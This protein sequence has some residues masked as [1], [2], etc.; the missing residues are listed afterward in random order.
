MAVEFPKTPTDL[1]VTAP[2]Y[3][4]KSVE[5]VEDRA[6]LTGRTEF[7]DNVVLPGMLHCAILRSPFAH[8]RIASIDASA[9]EGHPGVMA[10]LTREDA[11]RWSFPGS[12]VPEGWGTHCLATEKVRYVGEPVA[13]VAATS[14]YL[15]EDALEL[16]EVDYQP[17]EPVVEAL[18][19]AE[20]GGPLVNEEQGTNVMVHRVFTWGEVDRAFQEADHVFTESFRWHRVGAN[21]MENFGVISQWDPLEQSVTCRGTFQSPSLLALGRAAVLGL[22]IHK[23]RLISHPRG[24]SF[25]GKMGY[26]GTDITALLSRKAGG[27]PVKWIEDRMEYLTAGSSQA[28]DRHYQAS[29]AVRNDGTVTGFKVNLVEDLG[30]TG[31]GFGS[32]GAVKPLSSFTGCY[33]IPVA[34]YDLTLVATNKVSSGAYRGM[35][36]PPHNFVLEQLMD[37]AARGLDLDPAE[38]RRR[39]FIPP[40][41]FPYTIPSGNEYD[42]GRYEAALDAVLE[43]ADYPEL[44]RKQ[45]E[46]REQGRLL[47]IGVANTIEPGVF[48]WNAYA[49]VGMPGNGVPEGATVSI[50]ML[51]Q[52][53]VRVGFT[54]E[55]QGQFTLASQIA[56]DYFGVEMENVLVVPQDTHGAPPH[57]GPGGSRLGVAITG[58]ILGACQRVKEKL[59]RVAAVLLQTE[60]QN[61]ELLDGRLRVKGVPDA[62]MSVGDVAATMLTR[63]DLLPP[64]MEPSPEATYVWT[65]PGRTPVDEEGRTKSYLTAANACHVVLVEVDPQTGMVTI[66]GYW[67]ADDCGTRLNPD[68]VEGMTQGSVVQG[69]GAAL[70][71]EYV[72]DEEG[73]PLA[74]TFMDY[75]VPTIH[76]APVMEMKA[77]VTPSPFTPLG[78]KGCG[79]GAIHTAPAAVMCAINDALAPLGLRA[80]EVPAAPKRLWKLIESA[81]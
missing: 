48:D 41:Q 18:K 73:Q 9:A 39:N 80:T 2:R 30:A 34:G 31:E 57:F 3:V 33:A 42:S 79:E 5:K 67:I 10:V 22:P 49:S 59:A 21:P 68:T 75:L 6:H 16:I 15:A 40:D 8:A 14:R 13:A 1:P 72:Y 55:G 61:V 4:G 11:L 65:A 24:G 77:L 17:L 53:I 54:P 23:V 25:G 58:A 28:W 78:A 29:L 62:S 27:R 47:G 26:R 38:I 43:L 71:E 52:V 60:P 32:L 36:P 81:K 46:A 7:I 45:A 76:E 12:T 74:T 70:L 63:S 51:G 44:R 64:E 66:L 19:A 35:G 69:V 20:P 50:T 56:A 37:I